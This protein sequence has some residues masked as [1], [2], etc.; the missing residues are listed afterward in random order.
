V[1]FCTKLFC[2]TTFCKFKIDNYFTL[3]IYYYFTLYTYNYFTLDTH[4]FFT[5]DANN[6]IILKTNNNFILYTY[7][8][9]SLGTNYYFTLYT[10]YYFNETLITFPIP[11]IITYYI[12]IGN[13][14]VTMYIDIFKHVVIVTVQPPPAVSM[15]QYTVKICPDFHSS[16]SYSPFLAVGYLS[17]ISLQS[18]TKDFKINFLL[19]TSLHEEANLYTS[20]SLISCHHLF[21]GNGIF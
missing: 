18:L 11:H 9:S 12:L 8:L 1:L 2:K 17:R 4:Y 14:I 6:Y 16:I 19:Y 13:K 15:S 20:T 3:D 21:H 5:I 7:Y 10:D